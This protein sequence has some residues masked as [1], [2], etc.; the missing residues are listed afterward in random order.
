MAGTGRASAG[1][2]NRGALG[3]HLIGYV[4]IAAMAHTPVN[5]PLRPT[6]RALAGLAGLYLVIFGILGIVETG[7]EPFFDQGDGSA[8]GQGTNLGYSVIA[9][10]AGLLILAGVAIGRNVD[11]TLNTWG[12][13]AFMALGLAALAV[14]RTDANYLNF[15]LPTVMVTMAIGLLLLTAGMYGKAGTDEESKAAEAARLLL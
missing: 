8:I 3:G 2:L 10:A 12:G 14:I 13:Y 4:K 7:T 5:H 15:T 11:A 1:S 6:Y 9:I